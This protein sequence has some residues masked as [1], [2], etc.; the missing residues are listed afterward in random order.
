M[1][2]F[3]RVEHDMTILDLKGELD[4]SSRRT[5]MD[6]IDR[7][8]NANYINVILNLAEVPLIDSAALGM[9]VIAHQ[10][11]LLKQHRLSLLGPQPYVRQLLDLANFP[12]VIPIYATLNDAITR[13]NR[14]LTV[15]A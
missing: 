4:F 2:I 14:L 9:L 13:K 5:F 7:V 1:E 6:A 8:G 3:R 10:K 11:L 15:V 12:K